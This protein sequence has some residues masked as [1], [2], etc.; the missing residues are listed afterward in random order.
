MKHAIAVC[1]HKGGVGKTTVVMNLGL[2][3]A[4]LG[5]PVTLLELDTQ[6][7]FSASLLAED[8]L[9]KGLAGVIYE[10]A[11]IDEVIV[12]TKVPG[13]NIL[14]IGNTSPMQT[15]DIEFRL[16]EENVLSDIINHILAGPSSIVLCD[17]PPGFGSLVQAALSVV[18]HVLVPIQA[19]PLALRTVGRLLSGIEE[20]RSNENPSL[21]LL[22]LLLVMVDTHSDSSTSVLTSTWSAFDQSVVFD[23]MIPRREEYLKASLHGIPIAFLGKDLHPEGRRF[24]VLAQEILAKLTKKR[25][26]EEEDGKIFRTLL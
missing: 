24:Q 26:G 25:E 4:D 20:I 23:T 16:A 18:N 10:Q 3:F 1:S 9:E 17:F 7:S 19:E 6:G 2:A 8:G 15:T 12:K 5:I 14:P 13:L 22:G 11:D 21:S